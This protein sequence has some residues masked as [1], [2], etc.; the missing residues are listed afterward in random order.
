MGW[1]SVQSK[2]ANYGTS[3]M[4]NSQMDQAQIYRKQEKE[5]NIISF[6]PKEYKPNLHQFPKLTLED[7]IIEKSSGTAV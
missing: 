7:R 4:R 5:F 3:L 2:M 6:Y 1:D